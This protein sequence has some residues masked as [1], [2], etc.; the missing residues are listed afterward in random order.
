MHECRTRNKIFSFAANHLNFD[1]QSVKFLTE[2]KTDTCFSKT[3]FI[4]P[5]FILNIQRNPLRASACSFFKRTV[6]KYF[7]SNYLLSFVFI[8]LLLHIITCTGELLTSKFVFSVQMATDE[9]LPAGGGGGGGREGTAEKFWSLV[10]TWAEPNLVPRH[11][12]W[13]ENQSQARKGRR[14]YHE[15]LTARA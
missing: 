15:I 5:H 7:Q 12:F 13:F 4:S 2:T 6:L 14:Q 8:K 9:R 11:Q 10:S 1:L 3:N